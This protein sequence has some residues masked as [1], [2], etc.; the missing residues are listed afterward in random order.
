MWCFIFRYRYSNLFKGAGADALSGTLTALSH[1]EL[2]RRDQTPQRRLPAEAVVELS[3]S[4]AI[5]VPAKNS[6]T[7]E[8]RGEQPP[9]AP[10]GQLFGVKR[11]F[12]SQTTDGNDTLMNLARISSKSE[13]LLIM[14]K[15]GHGSVT[16]LDN[17]NMNT[18][19]EMNSVV[20][21]DPMNV[22]MPDHVV[23]SV[24]PTSTSALCTTSSHAGAPSHD[25]NSSMAMAARLPMNEGAPGG[26][27]TRSA[28]HNKN[29]HSR[30]SNASGGG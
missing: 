4:G 15:E 7:H 11:Q 12:M 29:S 14:E 5:S 20:P 17:E 13:K 22:C 24:A 6:A 18:D 28:N 30:R 8:R 26:V 27:S 19:S 23:S 9:P 21:F 25:Q 1:R 10:P 16:Q 2:S 3:R